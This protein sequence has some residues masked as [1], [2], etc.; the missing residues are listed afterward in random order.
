MSK[1][2]QN[3][4][5]NIQQTNTAAS[6]QPNPFS[7]LVNNKE[8][9]ELTNRLKK[10]KEEYNNYAAAAV[11]TFVPPTAHISIDPTP[12]RDD[13]YIEVSFEGVD[14]EFESIKEEHIDDMY[15]YLDK[16]AV[17]RAK[18]G[19]GHVKTREHTSTSNKGLREKFEKHGNGEPKDP[20]SHLYSGFVV[21]SE[22]EFLGFSG[23]LEC[24]DLKSA[25]EIVYLNRAIAWSQPPEDVVKQFSAK[26][27]LK[28]YKGVATMEASLM[29]QYGQYLK[30]NQK[31]IQGNPLESIVA[32]AR[33]D[34]PGSW[35]ALAK[36]GMQL[37]DI[38][39]CKQF[40]PEL[41]YHME[42]KI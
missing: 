22:G 1:P 24:E 12:N 21:K 8:A 39:A 15:N 32:K 29:L 30:K 31:K 26:G 33:I 35:K 40:G 37:L 18:F 14:Y 36:V 17:V 7:S 11:K 27:Q 28:K 3:M 38:S 6:V 4:T 42:K 19:D 13:V 2:T 41:R 9:D 20:N 16:D 23:L 5:K 25:A 10:L 34:N